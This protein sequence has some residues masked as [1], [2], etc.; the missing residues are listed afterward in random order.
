MSEPTTATW[1]S[2]LECGARPHDG[3]YPF[4]WVD[5]Y[6]PDADLAALAAD[7]PVLSDSPGA[8]RMPR[9]KRRLV[10][11]S[12]DLGRPGLADSWAHALAAVASPE[13]LDQSLAFV[14]EV[15]DDGPVG[16]VPAVV[17]A[18][19]GRL[20]AADLDV[21]VEAAE[22]ADGAYLPPHTDA[23]DKLVSCVLALPTIDPWPPE[24]GG[25]AQVLSPRLFRPNWSNALGD[26]A[27][28]EIVTEVPVVSNRLF[29]FVKTSSSWHAVSAA[30]PTDVHARRSF[31][32]A[33]V[34]SAE[35][36]ART[37]LDDAMREVA[38][39]EGAGR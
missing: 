31:N 4:G 35:G 8:Q 11:T 21:Q 3:P 39:A 25:Q 16:Q 1:R 33:V 30:T 7:F 29:W 18:A 27:D 23:A 26:P 24:W 5:H 37:G 6:L 20:V 10:L 22:L 19:H 34:V 32:V 2:L 14:R 12:A 15:S 9:G 13:Y 36:R 17:A 38:A 28:F